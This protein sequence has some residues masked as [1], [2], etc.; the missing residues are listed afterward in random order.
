MSPLIYTLIALTALYV[1]TL[2]GLTRGISLGQRRFKEDHD[3]DCT[4]SIVICAHNEAQKLPICLDAISRQSYD[5]AQIQT[6]VVD[7]RSTDKTR[8]VA[9]GFKDKISNLTLRSVE[10][11]RL[12]CP[13]KNALQ[14][15]LEAA[16]GDLILLTDADC[17][18]GID[19]VSS[20]VGSFQPETGM[21]IGRAPLSDPGHRWAPLLVFQSLLVNAIALGSAGIGIPLTCS[22]RNLAY[23][24]EAFNDVGGYGPVG[25]ILGGDDVLLM[26]AISAFGWPVVYNHDSRGSVSSPA[27]TDRQ[28]KRQIRY[29]SKARHFGWGILSLAILVYILHVLLF[30]GPI[31]AWVLPET[32]PILLTALTAKVI[33]DGVFLWQAARSLGQSQMLRWFP[34][35]EIVAIPYVAIVCALGT[36]RPS[37]WT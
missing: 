8:E 2:L 20:T 3:S 30:A 24:R 27:H 4:V 1:L 5:P 11:T 35:V 31:L 15:G 23:R 17:Q 19:W 16:T 22:G 9:M 33:V 26:R 13:K 7:D 14:T 29:Q 6:V 25:H 18:P 12:S 34:V 21:V 36:V 10:E 28:W 37:S 32:L